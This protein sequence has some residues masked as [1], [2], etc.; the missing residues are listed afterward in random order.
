MT[1]LN[2]DWS[3]WTH[4]S[5]STTQINLLEKRFLN[6]INFNLYISPIS[7][8]NFVSYLEFQLHTRQLLVCCGIFSYRDIDVLSQSLNP[9]YVK[10]LGL[11]LRPFEAM[12]L[13]AKQATSIFVMYAA[14][15]AT[16][17]SAGYW[18]VLQLNKEEIAM[19]ILSGIDIIKYDYIRNNTIITHRINNSSDT[20]TTTLITCK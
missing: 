18:I 17:V 1:W 2:T 20:T 19:I 10:R 13:L 7:Y 12:I 6:D 11:N 8:S 14:T 16:L 5:Y 3:E 9:E 4:Y 15:L